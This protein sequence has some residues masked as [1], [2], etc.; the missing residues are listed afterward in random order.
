MAEGYTMRLTE[1]ERLETEEKIIKLRK[2]EG[3]TQA[4][5]ADRFGVSLNFISLVWRKYGIS[6]PKK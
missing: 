6:T 4:V 1:A 2:E 5:L 3:L